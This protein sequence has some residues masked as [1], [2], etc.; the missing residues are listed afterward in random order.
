MTLLAEAGTQ[1][2][3]TASAPS[4]YSRLT[5]EWICG[6]YLTDRHQEVLD[7]TVQHI[8]ITVVSVLVGLVIAF[9]LALLARRLPRLESLILG[10]TTGIYTIPS[11]ALFPLMVPF[12]GLTATT[13]VLGLALYALTILVR[14]LL[15]GFRSVPEDVVE[16][17]TGLGYSR[18]KL[19][20]GIELPLALP[21]VMAGLRVAT[22]STVALTTVGSLVSYG[23]LGNLIKDGVSTNFRAELLTASVICVLLAV[24]LDVVLVGAQRVLTPWT[25]GVRA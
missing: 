15:E 6:Q 7:A 4:C 12:T 9:P 10:V 19:L 14:S 8:W 17:A 24:L 23:G 1:V 16:S 11:L 3:T 5:N 2:L 20:F 25:R 22:V 21:V 13:V 18:L